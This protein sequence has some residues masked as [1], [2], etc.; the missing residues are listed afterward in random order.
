MMGM[1][2]VALPPVFLA[3]SGDR[4][5]APTPQRR[6]RARREG[7]G[8]HSPDFQAGLALLAA[9]LILRLALPAAAD[10]LTA[11]ESAILQVPPGGGF[12]A[13][14]WNVWLVAAGAFVA[15]TIP[16]ALPLMAIGVL[17]GF[18]QNGFRFSPGRLL[19]DW[20]R[21][22]PVTGL[23]RMFSRDSAWALVKGLMKMAVI[24]LAAG[25]VIR[26]QLAM[27]PALI[28]MPLGAALGE[29]GRMLYA[30]MM[31]AAEA[32]LAVG[33]IDLGYQY[34]NFQ[35]SLKMSTQEI[36]DEVKDTEGNPLIKG[37]RR[38]IARRLARAGLKEVKTAQVVVTNPVHFAVALKWDEKTMQAPIVAAKGQDEMALHIRELAYQYEVPVVE[39]PP[40]ARALYQVP[41]GQPIEEEHY[42]AVAD[43]LAFL[44]KRRRP[45]GGGGP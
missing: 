42:Q 20:S 1:A 38:E 41:L 40:L 25:W 45:Y 2:G 23:I 28:A 33:L 11:M 6:Q 30:V 37:K 19:P 44:I 10:R 29:A 27:Y 39:N 31:R 4:S 17:W 9:V 16:V 12:A 35:Q 36:R 14:I 8:W 5:H 26:G 7:K 22:N 15:A 24:G 21:L 13:N 32:F 43:I 3:L 34:W 18:V